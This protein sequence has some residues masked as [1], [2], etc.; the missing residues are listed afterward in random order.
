[1]DTLSADIRHYS[2]YE[3]ADAAELLSK[4]AALEQA[5]FRV[6]IDLGEHFYETGAATL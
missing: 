5:G 2:H 4:V 6:C 1:V 3:F